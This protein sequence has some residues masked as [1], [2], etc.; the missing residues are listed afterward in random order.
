MAINYNRIPK[1]LHRRFND[2]KEYLE[3]L[4][5]SLQDFQNGRVASFK[6]ILFNLRVLLINRKNTDIGLLLTLVVELKQLEPKVFFKGM[7]NIPLSN[8]LSKDHVLTFSEYLNSNAASVS[9]K[10]LT[11]KEFVWEL[12]SQDGSHSD[13]GISPEFAIGESFLIGGLNPNVRTILS[14]ARTVLSVGKEFISMQHFV[15]DNS[16]SNVNS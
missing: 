11:V 6:E 5:K 9:G 13:E 12:A 2:L 1:P 14:I 4:E 10:E 8:P 7:E 3:N 16:R 15:F